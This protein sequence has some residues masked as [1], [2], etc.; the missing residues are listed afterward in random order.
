MI[1]NSQFSCDCFKTLDIA[2]D[3]KGALL[4]VGVII[5]TSGSDISTPR[6]GSRTK[7]LFANPGIIGVNRHYRLDAS[8]ARELDPVYVSSSSD[9]NRARQNFR[10]L[11]KLR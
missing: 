5:E 6:R 8:F 3:M 11:P 2:S 7:G 1:S 4:K 9:A 10:K